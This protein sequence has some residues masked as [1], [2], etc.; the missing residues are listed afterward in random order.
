MISNLRAMLDHIILAP[1][2]ETGNATHDK[3]TFPCVLTGR[4]GRG[5]FGSRLMNGPTAVDL[6]DREGPAVNFPNPRQH[7]M[8]IVHRL[9]IATKH[10]LLIPFDRAALK[11][12]YE[13]ERGVTR[14]CCRSLR[15]G[16]RDVAEDTALVVVHVAVAAAD[17]FGLFDDPIEPLG[18]CIGPGHG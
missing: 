2:E 1:V 12:L 7:P 11:N 18:A 6:G 17:A 3:L 15:S 13:L 5:L 8:H 14:S 9:D 16:D 4:T 10:R